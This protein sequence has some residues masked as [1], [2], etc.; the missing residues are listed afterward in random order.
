MG[1]NIVSKSNHTNDSTQSSAVERMIF[2]TGEIEEYGITNAIANI[3]AM[4]AHSSEPIDIVM[5]TYGG[6]VHD[7]FA[8]YDAI[9]LVRS[10]NGCEI[11]TTGLGK[12]MSAGVMILAAGSHGK[13]F[14][15]E[16]TSIMMHPVST[17]VGGN[18]IHIEAELNEMKRLQARMDTYVSRHSKL[19]PEQV[20]KIMTLGHDHVFDAETALEYG[21]ADR[22]IGTKSAPLVK[23][24]TK[25]KKK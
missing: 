10:V 25:K 23:K 6:N 14:V 24:T 17:T 5:S 1:R 20:N 18:A 12:V 7:A 19:S 22:I 2:L 4:G 8:L 16:S 15:G 11:R 9:N 13:R 21:I 3:I